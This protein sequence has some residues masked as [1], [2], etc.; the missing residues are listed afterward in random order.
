MSTDKEPSFDAQ[1]SREQTKEERA[2]VKLEQAVSGTA[3]VS[4]NALIREAMKILKA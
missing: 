2:I 1:A 3:Q 4:K